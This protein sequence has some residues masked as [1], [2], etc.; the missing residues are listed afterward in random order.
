MNWGFLHTVKSFLASRRKTKLN[1]VVSHYLQMQLSTIHWEFIILCKDSEGINWTQRSMAFS[2]SMPNVS[3]LRTL[4]HWHQEIYSEP[5]FATTQSLLVDQVKAP[6]KTFSYTI[7]ICVVAQIIVLTYVWSTMRSK[8]RLKKTAIELKL[9]S[10]TLIWTYWLH[11][12]CC[13]RLL[14]LFDNRMSIIFFQN[15]TTNPA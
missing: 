1:L 14:T 9:L 6:A 7:M 4:N 11:L 10:M 3:L 5:F 13:L 8:L 12:H 2:I 15:F